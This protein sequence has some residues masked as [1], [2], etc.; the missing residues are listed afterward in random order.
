MFLAAL[1]GGDIACVELC[2]LPAE[3]AARRR[4]VDRLRP[5][6]QGRGIACLVAEDAALAAETGCDGVRVAGPAVYRA[7][8]RI[9][10]PG[11]IVG[12]D[13]GSSR[14]D[15]MTAGEAGADF[16]RLADDADLV[17]WW[18]E[19]MEIPCVS[20]A[21]GGEFLEIGGPAVWTAAD[22]RAAI[23]ATTPR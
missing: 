20:A 19:L 1:D 6:A 14:D 21:P 12:V 18:A 9:V 15:A 2:C 8:R 4:A 16:V 13:A 17:A 10:G 5:I 11:A 23:R 3:P 22:P 7:A